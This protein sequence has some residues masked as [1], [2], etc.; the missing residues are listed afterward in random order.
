MKK[1]FTEQRGRIKCIN[2]I[3]ELPTKEKNKHNNKIERDE[4]KV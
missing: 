2:E 1:V 3:R 4:D